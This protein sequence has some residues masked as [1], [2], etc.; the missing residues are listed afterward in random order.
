MKNQLLKLRKAEGFVSI[1]TIMV[2]ALM[3]LAGLVAYNALY[4]GT[5]AEKVSYA[6][7]VLND[8]VPEELF[9]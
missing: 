1:E 5:L 9:E 7:G 4:A 3:V 2:A 8:E 6:K